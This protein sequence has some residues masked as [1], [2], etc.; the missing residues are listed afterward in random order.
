MTMAGARRIRGLPSETSPHETKRRNESPLESPL[1]F[2][3]FPLAILSILAPALPAPAAPPASPAHPVF[4]G[5]LLSRSC[6]NHYLCRARAK[7]HAQASAETDSAV[8]ALGGAA[9]QPS[10]KSRGRQLRLRGGAEEGGGLRGKAGGDSD[11]P[12]AYAQEAAAAPHRAPAEAAIFG[13]GLAVEDAW[14][15]LTGDDDYEGNVTMLQ[16]RAWP[17]TLVEFWWES[18][19]KIRHSYDETA[20]DVMCLFPQG[21]GSNFSAWE[22]ESLAVAIQAQRGALPLPTL[23]ATLGC[24]V[25]APYPPRAPVGAA[26][27]MNEGQGIGMEDAGETS[28]TGEASETRKTGGGGPGGKWWEEP[29]ALG[30]GRGEAGSWGNHEH[31][32]RWKIA[33]GRRER[34]DAAVPQGRLVRVTNLEFPEMEMFLTPTG[35]V[36]FDNLGSATV[37][38][39]DTAPPIKIAASQACRVMGIS[40][41]GRKDPPP[42]REHVWP[43]KAAKWPFNLPDLKE[44]HSVD[45]FLASKAA[46][47][48][49]A[50]GGKGSRASSVPKDSKPEVAKKPKVAKKPEVAKKAPAK[51]PASETGLG[52]ESG[53][54]E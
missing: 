25:F 46:G 31:S 35:F 52:D 20:S 40:A 24:W 11:E 28:G 49:T 9:A 41:A 13:E 47:D 36:H 44:W 5:D 53:P 8:Q 19:G 18:C 38:I 22:N 23:P 48:G 42:E 17:Y 6:D 1:S 14:D 15:F 54:S 30:G 4:F 29:G 32:A 10:S 51:R 7:Q 39:G 26:G 43:S 21:S 16:L 27:Q 50:A 12:M 45:D 37:K 33:Q 2:L 34:R 3:L